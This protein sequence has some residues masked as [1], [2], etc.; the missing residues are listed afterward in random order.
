M[1]SLCTNRTTSSPTLR[2]C[3]KARLKVAALPSAFSTVLSSVFPTAFPCAP[4][5][6]LL[7][8]L[9][10]APSA[11]FPTC[12]RP[13][14][15]PRSRAHLRPCSRPSFRPCSRPSFRPRSPLFAQAQIIA[16][17]IVPMAKKRGCV[18]HFRCRA[19]RNFVKPQVVVFPMRRFLRTNANFRQSP[20]TFGNYFRLCEHEATP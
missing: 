17:T 20:R 10:I 14:S 12:S 5:S 6:T 9:S 19:C 8:A 11:A 15:Q 18:G 3:N 2:Q 16:N 7:C 13:C 1:A 4:L